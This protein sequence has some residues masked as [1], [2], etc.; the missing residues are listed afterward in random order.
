[1]NSTFSMTPCIEFEMIEINHFN[2]KKSL[3]QLKSICSMRD[4]PSQFSIEM[5][6]NIVYFA[7]L[8]SKIC[9]VLSKFKLLLFYF[10]INLQL[11]CFLE[12]PFF[13]FPFAR[14]LICIRWKAH[15]L[16]SRQAL[17]SLW[18]TPT[19]VF[20]SAFWGI[21]KYPAQRQ[22]DRKRRR[23]CFRFR[24]RI[25]VW[26]RDSACKRPVD[27]ESLLTLFLP[28]EPE[29]QKVFRLNRVNYGKVF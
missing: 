21:Q 2:A 9:H 28:N 16:S 1:M 24:I 20:R 19:T 26:C 17:E 6:E 10:C 5:V 14:S 25:R 15:Q 12:K 3:K 13:N 7:Y 23:L 29:Y 22:S 27:P 8:S 4:I 11:K 18:Q